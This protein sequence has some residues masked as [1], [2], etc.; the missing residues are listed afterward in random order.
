MVGKVSGFLFAGHL[1]ERL[2]TAHCL[3][4][5][6]FYFNSLGAF[7]L[8]DGH[9]QN[10]LLVKETLIKSDLRITRADQLSF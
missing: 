4:I 5:K 10:P 1:M 2:A 6:H 3:L 7:F 9:L 8:F